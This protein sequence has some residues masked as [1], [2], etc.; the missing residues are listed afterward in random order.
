GPGLDGVQ[1]AAPTAEAA[2]ATAPRPA[3]SCAATAERAEAA[4]AAHA[5]VQLLVVARGRSITLSAA[6]AQFPQ[7]L[8]RRRVVRPRLLAASH[9]LGSLLVLPDDGRTVVGPLAAGHAPHLLAG[10]AVEGHQEGFFLVVALQEEALTVEHG[11]A[12]RAMPHHHGKGTE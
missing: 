6:Q 5:D 4:A 12:G 9:Q 8:A 11:R 7:H 10:L 3:S 2:P 1:R